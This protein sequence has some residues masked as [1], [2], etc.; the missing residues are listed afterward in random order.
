MYHFQ[1]V[2]KNEIAPSKKQLIELIGWQWIWRLVIYIL[3][4]DGLMMT[5]KETVAEFIPSHRF[6][7]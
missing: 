5:I 6:L 1:Y 2:S 3:Y 4:P 7:N